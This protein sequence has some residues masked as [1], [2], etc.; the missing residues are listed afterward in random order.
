MPQGHRRHDE[1]IIPT[2]VLHTRRQTQIGEDHRPEA[3]RDN[4]SP[5]LTSTQEVVSDV[6]KELP[7]PQ[8]QIGSESLHFTVLL[9]P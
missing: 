3:G 8:V 6:P 2:Q 5:L 9:A 7:L 4:N 1:H